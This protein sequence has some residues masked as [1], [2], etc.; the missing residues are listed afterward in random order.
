[1][2]EDTHLIELKGITKEFGDTKALDNVNLYIRKREFITLL[3]P[4]GCGK[5]T[6]LNMICGLETPTSGK[7]LF[8]EEDVTALPPELR[9]V[10]MVFQNYALYP[11]MTVADNMAFPLKMT[12]LT[13]EEKKQIRLDALGDAD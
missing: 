3:G 7:I 8:G 12:K 9:G 13:K 4:S 10:G 5:S 11:H 6:T 1:M 2:V